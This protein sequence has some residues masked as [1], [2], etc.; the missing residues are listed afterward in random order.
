MGTAAGRTGT[1]RWRAWQSRR[2]RPVARRAAPDA[3]RRLH[4]RLGTSDD[5]TMAELFELFDDVATL[6]S[7]LTDEIV[8]VSRTV[9]REGQ[10]GE[11]VRLEGAL[12]GGR[13]RSTR[14]TRSSPTCCSPPPRCARADG[15]GRGRLSQKMALEMSGRTVQGEFLRIGTTVN[16]DGRPAARL[17]Q[18][19]H[20]RRRE[21]GS[22]GR[23]GGQPT[24]P[25]WPDVEGPDGLGE[26]DGRRSPRRCAHSPRS[27]G[28]A[29]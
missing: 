8:R 15:G 16:T 29:A 21:V 25:A 2:A 17:R 26:R 24:S 20:A 13:W 28:V 3:R 7:G 27:Q 14:S 22:E 10:M 18:R 5:P 12:G 9:G 1:A 19:G 6:R 23:L 11:R 4:R